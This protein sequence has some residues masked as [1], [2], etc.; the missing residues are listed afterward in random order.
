M[1]ISKHFTN[2]SYKAPLINIGARDDQT[3]HL[4][5]GI[6]MRHFKDIDLIY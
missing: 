6:S 5:R 1:N 2:G 4:L 3:E